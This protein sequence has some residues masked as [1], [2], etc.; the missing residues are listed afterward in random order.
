MEYYPVEVLG[1]QGADRT[2]VRF[3]SPDPEVAARLLLRLGGTATLVEGD[4]VGARLRQLGESLLAT[5][6]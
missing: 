2:R 4:E 5:Y 6:R 1:E 3:W